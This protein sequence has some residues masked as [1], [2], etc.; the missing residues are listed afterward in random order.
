MGIQTRKGAGRLT[1]L[2]GTVS[3]F[4]D[5]PPRGGYPAMSIELEDVD[6]FQDDGNGGEAAAHQDTFSILMPVFVWEKVRDHLCTL[7]DAE[8]AD[9][10]IGQRTE[11]EVTFEGKDGG[12]EYASYFPIE[13]GK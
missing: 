1:R 7:A 13:V 12:V 11:F 8:D 5:A 2:V 6:T 3:S 4:E 10:I 9:S